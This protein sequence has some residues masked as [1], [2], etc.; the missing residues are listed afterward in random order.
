MRILLVEDDEYLA[1]LL[2]HALV[3]QHH[4]VDRSADGLTGWTLA[5]ERTYD[6][7]LLDVML[8]KLDGISFCRQLRAKGSQAPILLMTARDASTDKVIGLDAGA[9]DYLVKPFSPQEL[10]AR[11]R[12]LWRRGTVA[13]SPIL[14]CGELHLDPSACEVTYSGALVHLTPKEYAILELFLRNTQRVYSRSAI[15]DQLWGFEDLPGEDTVKAHIKGLRQKLKAVGAAD[16]IETVYG[17][18]YRL[19]TSNT[20]TPSVVRNP[21]LDLSKSPKNPEQQTRSLVAK[22]WERAKTKT[23]Q[24]IE[25]LEAAV[26]PDSAL[27]GGDRL[28]RRARQEAHKLAGSLGTF[29]L[30]E[31]SQ[32]ARQIEQILQIETAL[33]P[34]HQ[35]QLQQ[36]VASLRQVL[37]E[38]ICPSLH[39]QTK[40]LPDKP[41]KSSTAQEPLLLIVDDDQLLAERVGQEAKQWGLRTAIA[42]TPQVARLMMESD[43]PDVVLL[44]LSFA[45]SDEA[46]PNRSVQDSELAE[47]GLNLLAE[48]NQQT[49]HLPVLVFTG[50]G[51]AVDRVTVAR[52]K[53]RRF[54]QKP[55]T[56]ACVLEA[57]TEVL[58]Q[59]RKVESSILVVDDDPLILHALQTLLE[60]WGL[61]VA[62]LDN[63]LNFW[64]ELE[65]TKPDLLVLDIEM[66]DLDGIELCQTLRNDPH[67]NWL[68]VLFL[69]ART[70]AS[71]I[72]Q[73]FAVG[74][75]DYASKPVI[76][77]E[78]ITR[79]LNR[80]ERTRLLRNRTET[81]SLTGTANRQQ[82]TRELNKLLQLAQR[83]QQPFC[84][85][86]LRLD[87][88][89]QAN[90]QYGHG[91][92]D[93][94]LQQVAQLLQHKLR[95]ED[96][97]SRWSGAEFVI[98]M[99]G[100]SRNNSVEWL[101]EILEA[102]RQIETTVE[103]KAASTGTFSAGVAQYPEDGM[104]LRDL[105]QSASAA[106][107]LAE[108]AGGDRVL[109][110]GWQPLQEASLKTDVVLVHPD[111][112]FAQ[113]LL[114]ALET[115]GYHSYWLQDS[116]MAIELLAG[117]NPEVRSQI[118]LIEKNLPGLDGFELLKHLSQ[119]K[120]TQCSKLILLSLL[121]GESEKALNLGA[122]DYITDPCRLPIVMQRLRRAC[123]V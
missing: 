54:L 25:I 88:L 55:T 75:D 40:P 96:V 98:G 91:F 114:Y 111:S 52:L 97:V 6:L 65:A 4:T 11:M 121:P 72:Q 99:Y 53:G 45:E 85:S 30:A 12:A 1:E 15:L 49:P 109:A 60:P 113:P 41:F 94:V 38:A 10:L 31:G 82:S 84:L 28:W 18:G 16:V 83:S 108:G 122:F 13:K 115:R 119:D 92:G 21:A 22:I 80:I 78:L 57:V 64:D 36:Q 123:A 26:S 107:E 68:P 103:G 76:A 19:N 106:L 32:L 74:A 93:R 71:T 33:S 9:D 105:Y 63:S 46:G 101:A 89:K 66:P 58:A 62:T 5:E 61:R 117:S 7:I 95:P 50:R 17:L 37:E 104:L 8:P 24:Q 70:D 47:A 67:W 73:V 87:R 27:E 23:L 48:L 79:I 110:V 39:K 3:E 118:I 116:E 44:D 69:T 56:P 77:P 2:T 20:T 81:D 35:Q 100:M 29:G 42:P 34:D 14:K 90:D 102:L 86:A 51:Q 112:A 59:D 43:R 120:V